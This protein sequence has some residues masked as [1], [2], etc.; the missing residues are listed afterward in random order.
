MYFTGCL[1]FYDLSLTLGHPPKIIWIKSGNISTSNL[2]KLLTAKSNQI[3]IFADDTEL[4]C[5]EIFD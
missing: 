1:H 2:E 4:S 5:L 3:Q